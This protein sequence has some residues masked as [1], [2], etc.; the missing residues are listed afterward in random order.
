MH[1]NCHKAKHCITNCSMLCFPP[2][3]KSK[4]IYNFR[5]GKWIVCHTVLKYKAHITNFKA[6]EMPLELVLDVRLTLASFSVFLLEPE[7]F[8]IGNLN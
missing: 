8:F 6:L 5:H 1:G 2:P 3:P 7:S 4:K